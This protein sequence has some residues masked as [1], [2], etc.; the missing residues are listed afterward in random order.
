ME[1][2]GSGLA[3]LVS[4]LALVNKLCEHI[5]GSGSDQG[6]GS[7]VLVIAGIQGYPIRGNATRRRGKG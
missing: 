1:S 3:V 6:G 7:C 5:K 2:T 4:T